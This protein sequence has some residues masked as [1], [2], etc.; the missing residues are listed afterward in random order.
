MGIEPFLTTSTVIMVIA[1]RLVRIICPKCK[2]E[3]EVDYDKIKH[4]GV[5]PEMVDGKTKITLARG[6]GCDFCS[7][8][9]YKGRKACFE[10][11]EV[12]DKIRD[13]VL[14]RAPTHL[15]KQVAREEGMITLREAALRKLLRQETTLEEVLR[16]TFTE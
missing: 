4:L 11:M 13:L 6:T 12:S 16:V 14:E 9:G 10:V 1:Q 2:E 5:T 7:N 3:F 15:I 8:T